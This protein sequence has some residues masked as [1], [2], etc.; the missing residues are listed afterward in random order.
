MYMHRTAGTAIGNPSGGFIAL[1]TGS[2]TADGGDFS[3][4]GED[5]YFQLTGTLVDGVVSVE[6]IFAIDAPWT[7]TI[8]FDSIQI[9]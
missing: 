9:L 5:S 8:Y 2:S 3:F 4:A 1:H 6:I 7:G